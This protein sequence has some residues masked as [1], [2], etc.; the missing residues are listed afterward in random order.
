MYIL[1]WRE[2]ERFRDRVGGRPDRPAITCFIAAARLEE[3][4]DCSGNAILYYSTLVAGM[5]SFLVER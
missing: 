2:T 3:A 1:L 5:R 4:T